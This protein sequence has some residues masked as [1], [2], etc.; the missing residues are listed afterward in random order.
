MQGGNFRYQDVGVP[1]KHYSKNKDIFRFLQYQVVPFGASRQ[2]NLHVVPDFGK[3]IMYL[4]QESGGN[5]CRQQNDFFPVRHRF[6]YLAVSFPGNY[7][8]QPV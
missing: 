5:S 7:F 1:G 2:Y 6:Y 3:H 4:V 8:R